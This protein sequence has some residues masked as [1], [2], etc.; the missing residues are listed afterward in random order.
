MYGCFVVVVH[1]LLSQFPAGINDAAS[2]KLYLSFFFFL[3]GGAKKKMKKKKKKKE[4][5]LHKLTRLIRLIN[6]F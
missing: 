4:S 1:M 2:L 5:Q 6:K 3:G